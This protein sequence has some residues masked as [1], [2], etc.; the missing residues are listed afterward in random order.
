MVNTRYKPDKG[1]E[2]D[3]NQLCNKIRTLYPDI[4][5]C[6]IDVD[7]DYDDANDRWTVNLKKDKKQLKTFLEP[8]DADLCMEGK[9]CVSLGIE[10]NQLRDSLDRRPL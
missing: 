8:G 3:K 1:G 6:G 7:V 2:M 10:I 5:E 4:G 9:Q